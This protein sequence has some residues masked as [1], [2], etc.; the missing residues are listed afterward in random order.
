MRLEEINDCPKENI[1][2]LRIAL[3]ELNASRL[4]ITK[5]DIH[6]NLLDK[7]L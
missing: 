3:K 6:G 2:N 5:V 7:Q 4:W 1:D